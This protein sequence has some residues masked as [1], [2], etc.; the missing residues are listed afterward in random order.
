MQ[1]VA[2]IMYDP[3]GTF[4]TLNEPVRLPPEIEHVEKKGEANVIPDN[5]QL[6]SLG[7]NPE[8]HT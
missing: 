7:E 8:P 4:P 1:A 3:A 6:V 2:V 5:E